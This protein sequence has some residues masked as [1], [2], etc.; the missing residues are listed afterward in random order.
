MKKGVFELRACATSETYWESNVTAAFA[1][2]SADARAKKG[3][4]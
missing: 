3:N 1:G 2:A 4:E